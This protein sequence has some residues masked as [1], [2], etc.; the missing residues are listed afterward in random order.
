MALSL[1]PTPPQRSDP[2]NFAARGDAFMAALPTFVSEFNAQVPNVVAGDQGITGN[3]TVNGNSTLGNA[4]TDV[5]TIGVNGIVK[6]ASGNV[7]IGVTPSAWGASGRAIQF[8]GAAIEGRLSSQALTIFQNGYYDGTNSRYVTTG[9]TS[10]YALTGGQHYWFAA[11]SGTAGSIIGLV[12]QMM[13]DAN[14]N[15]LVGLTS[16][17]SGGAAKLSVGYEGGATR[18][19][20]S[21]KPT[22]DSTTAVYFANAAGSGIGS[23]TQTGSAVAYNTTSDQRLKTNIAPAKE[24]GG[25]IDGIKVRSFDWIYSGEHQEYGFI[26]QELEQHASYAVHR[27]DNEDEMLSVDY[28]KL[29]PLLVKEVQSLRKRVAELEAA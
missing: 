14:G 11:P 18:Y 6:D 12:Q 19:G 15:L 2:A 5:I 27:P 4:T 20:I 17:I 10:A 21:L 24:A 1:L 16:G 28:S 29:V 8:P 3:L 13:L 23:I 22:A 9:A 25:V 26:A 7:G